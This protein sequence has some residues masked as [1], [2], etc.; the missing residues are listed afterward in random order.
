M[1]CGRNPGTLFY[2]EN[3]F[4]SL[5]YEMDSRDSPFEGIDVGVASN[6]TFGDL[7]GDGDL[8]LVVGDE[9]HKSLSYFENTGSTT[10]AVYIQRKDD[11]NPCVGIAAGKYLNAPF[12]ADLDGDGDLDLVVGALN[13]SFGGICYWEN[14]GTSSV[15]E[16]KQMK[17]DKNPFNGIGYKNSNSYA[18]PLL[19]DI[20]NDGD[21]DLMYTESRSHKVFFYQNIGDASV[22]KFVDATDSAIDPFG[23]IE[24]KVSSDVLEAYLSIAFVDADEDGDFDIVSSDYSGKFYYYRNCG[25]AEKPKF[26]QPNS[27]FVD[28]MDV[29]CYGT[30]TVGDFNGDGKPDL[31]SGD[32]KGNLHAFLHGSFF[33]V[34]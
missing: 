34:K 25:S 5:F 24:F 21:L 12:L 3:T 26:D 7:D 9:Y 29:G 27:D 22:P 11:E 32:E 10:E 31:L 19:V 20:D 14:I 18:R 17:G 2:A 13:M 28:Y 30:P 15:P 33:Y 4:L 1:V 23:G 8:D 6:P 16:F